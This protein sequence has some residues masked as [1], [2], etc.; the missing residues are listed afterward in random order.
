M[1]ELVPA[2]LTNDISDFRK[3]Y[4]ELFALSHHFNK[5]HID[6]ADG[7]FVDNKTLMP[8]DL[9]FLSAKDGSPLVLMGHFMTYNPQQ[10]F[11][12]A[13]KAGFEWAIIHYEAFQ[14][15]EEAVSAIGDGVIAGLKMG[16]AI[17]PETPLAKTAK[18]LTKVKLVQLMGIHPGAQGR[19]FIPET[20]DRIRELKSLTQNVI[21]AVDGGE[22]LGIASQCV[23]AGADMIVVGSEILNA[24][25]PKEALEAFKREIEMV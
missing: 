16:L 3:K 2:I 7:E 23:K 15:A 21:I 22:K 24:T 18:V 6:F 14:S 13:K 11:G 12:D 17:N 25:H 4:A 5:L 9:Q 8:A 20:L 1:T 10:Y 19:T